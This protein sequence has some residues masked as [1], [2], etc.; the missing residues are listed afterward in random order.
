[1]RRKAGVSAVMPGATMADVHAAVVR[2]LVDGLVALGV[3]EGAVDEVIESGAYKSFFPH[4]TSH[5]LGLDV[6][7]PGDYAT[8]GVSRILEPGMV[9]TVE[10]GLY[11]GFQG[12]G[13][14]ATHFSGLGVRIEDDV[15]VTEEGCEVLSAA[16]PTARSDVE[17]LVGRNS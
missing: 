4:Q 12:S 8:D 13:E 17:A 9:F 3:L 16:L 10:P 15:L 7:D 6:H 11:F 5:W 2:V 14:R 1:M